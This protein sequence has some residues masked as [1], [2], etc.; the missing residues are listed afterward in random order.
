MTTPLSRRSV[1]TGFATVVVGGVAGFA[2]ARNSDA[3]KA[4][5]STS[6][7]NGY[8]LS[9][10]PSPTPTGAKAPGTLLTPLGNVPRGGGVVLSSQQVVVTRDTAGSVHAFSAVCTHAQCLVTQVSNGTIDCPCHGS[11]FN[12]TTGAV[13]TG[14]AASPLPTVSI[15]VKG[16]NVY[17][18]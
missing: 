4:K 12:A 2:V 16:G 13:V 1:L 11:Q 6:T 14:P 5:P 7:S 9:T 3:A 17:R 10:Q 18:T 8:R 15:K